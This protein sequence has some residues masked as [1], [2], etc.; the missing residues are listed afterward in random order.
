ME[1]ALRRIYDVHMKDRNG[2]YDARIVGKDFTWGRLRIDTK[3]HYGS[4][5]SKITPES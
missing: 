1:T 3:S 4:I 5:C 2:Y